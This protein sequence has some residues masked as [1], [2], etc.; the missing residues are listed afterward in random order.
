MNNVSVMDVPPI[1]PDDIR[2]VFAKAACIYS[3]SQVEKAFDQMA[4][5]IS[6]ELADSNPIFLCVVIKENG[7]LT[8][9]RRSK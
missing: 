6:H 2:K 8:T 7:G 5:E 1:L 3:K 9:K 4:M